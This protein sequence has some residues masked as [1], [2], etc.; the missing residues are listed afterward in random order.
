[1]GSQ[2]KECQG[3]LAVQGQIL[4]LLL[5]RGALRL[6][7]VG[8]PVLMEEN[9]QISGDPGAGPISLGRAE[10]GV[11]NQSSLRVSGSLATSP[12]SSLATSP[13]T[14]IHRRGQ[15]GAT[16]DFG[17][18]QEVEQANGCPSLQAG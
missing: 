2:L 3:N 9:K 13:T 10:I 12:T 1:M 8:Q 4:G 16:V 5:I 7:M 15:V 17:S 6:M 11:N 18:R 14:L